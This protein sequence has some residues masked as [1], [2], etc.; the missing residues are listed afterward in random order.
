MSSVQHDESLVGI[1]VT[2]PDELALQLDQLE[3]IVARLGD[4]LWGPLVAEAGQFVLRVDR[5][6]RALRSVYG[7]GVTTRAIGGRSPTGDF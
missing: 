3:L 4:H 5:F 1:S 6:G 2:V 7:L